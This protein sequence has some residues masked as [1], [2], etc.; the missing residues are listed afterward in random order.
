MV[1]RSPKAVVLFS[2]AADKAISEAWRRREEE[3]RLQ[4]H[5]PEA[6]VPLFAEDQLP[7]VRSFEST[8]EL[9]RQP[10]LEQM[11]VEIVEYVERLSWL[12]TLRDVHE[13]LAIRHCG[14]F[15]VSHM[16]KLTRELHDAAAIELMPNRLAPNTRVLPKALSQKLHA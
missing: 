6:F 7:P 5:P 3:E 14:M 4:R 11:R 16:N 1:T 13:M 10:L 15:R 2:D 8:Y 9:R 12:P